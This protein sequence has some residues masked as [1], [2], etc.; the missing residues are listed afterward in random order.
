MAIVAGSG[1][2]GARWAAL[3]G[4]AAMVAVAGSS[5]AWARDGGSDHRPT[6]VRTETP[7]KHLVV[8]YD[9]NVSFD[10][11]FGTYPKAANTDGTSFTAA[12]NTPKN[13]NNLVNSG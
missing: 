7:I 9:E 11:Y 1:K 4:A 5:P 2:R 10:H 6:H 13:V 12:K 3:V 8:I